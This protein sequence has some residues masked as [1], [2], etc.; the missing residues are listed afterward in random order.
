[1]GPADPLDVWRGLADGEGQGHRGGPARRQ[2]QQVEEGGAEVRPGNHQQVAP[3][4]RRPRSVRGGAP[5]GPPT[6]MY[7]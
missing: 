6:I 1:M 4:R 3:L 7:V 5:P 2:Q